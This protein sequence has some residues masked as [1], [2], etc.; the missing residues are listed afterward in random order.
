MARNLIDTGVYFTIGKSETFVNQAL[1][2]EK[3]GNLAIKL[4]PDTFIKKGEEVLVRLVKVVL[5]GTPLP[6]G[7]IKVLAANLMDKI[8]I[9]VVDLGDLYR[10]R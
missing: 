6:S 1:S 2:T 10:Q 9:T 7:E 4:I 3:D 5:G 8:A